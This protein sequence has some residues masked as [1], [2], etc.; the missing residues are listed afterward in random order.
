MK[1]TLL[2][3]ALTLGSLF[4]LIKACQTVVLKNAIKTNKEISQLDSNS[5]S[6]IVPEEYLDLFLDKK[7]I[8]CDSSLTSKHRSLVTELHN[9]QFYILVYKLGAANKLYLNN[10]YENYSSS[11]A[12]MYSYYIDASTSKQLQV[13]YKLGIMGEIPSLYFNL[14]G[15]HTQAL[16]KN[17]SVAYYYSNFEN[18]SIRYQKEGKIDIYGKAKGNP[19]RSKAPL[20][21]M[22]LKRNNNLYFILLTNRNYS[23]NLDLNALYN[24]IIK[25]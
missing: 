4:I 16:K 5:Y 25:S 3:I 20:E 17:D 7:N 13:Q 6:T 10:V 8:V 23:T 1:K 18:F 9:N 24:L 14:Y 19:Q 15:D 12:P 21:V 2:V 11:G 22:F